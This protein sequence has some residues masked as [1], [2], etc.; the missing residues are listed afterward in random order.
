MFHCVDEQEGGGGGEFSRV[1][2]YL[3]AGEDVTGI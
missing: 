3:S 1:L 2:Q